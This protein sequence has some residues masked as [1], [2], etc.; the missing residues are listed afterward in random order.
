MLRAFWRRTSRKAAAIREF[1]S[2]PSWITTLQR[3]AKAAEKTVSY[4]IRIFDELS[5]R[6]RKFTFD[7]ESWNTS[8]MSSITRKKLCLGDESR[9]YTV[10]GEAFPFPDRNDSPVVNEPKCMSTILWDHNSP[11]EKVLI[12][13]SEYFPPLLWHTLKPT[14]AAVSQVFSEFV[15]VDAQHM[16][17]QLPY[18]ESVQN[19][20]E[21][22]LGDRL[23]ESLNP[24]HIKN[25]FI[26]DMRKRNPLSISLDYPCE[27]NVFMGTSPHFRVVEDRFMKSNPF[28][29]GWPLLLSEGNDFLEDTPLR[30]AAFRSIFSKSLLLVHSRLDLQVDHRHTHLQADDGIEDIIL[31]TPI[32]CS[33]N[34]PVNQ[35]LCGGRPLVRRF[36]S[37]MGTSF[38]LDTPVDVLAA[39]VVEGTAIKGP[40]ELLC[41]LAF[42]DNAAKK[43]P[44]VE[45]VFRISDS[46]LSANRIVGQ[47]AYT[48]IY[49]A[50]LSHDLFS[51]KVFDSFW[52]HPSDV[53]RVACAKGAHIIGRPDLVQKIIDN[54]GEG[55]TKLMLEST[56]SMVQHNCLQ[57]TAETNSA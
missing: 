48:I 2:T 16:K 27:F 23:T 6:Q 26:E 51:E 24:M 30:M 19:Q 21:M 11:T 55:R 22:L 5:W 1:S 28:V 13:L 25:K 42:L 9:E 45:R 20:M 34:Y 10:I 18:Y 15:E 43:A 44:D 12:Q 40:D 35:R 41:E 7:N 17:A 38:P 36:N 54:E 52:N 3:D 29:F 37:V 39:L 32:F 50:L 31:E 57:S 53:V 46:E 49:L 8:Q 4:D 47:L 14:Y 33:I 56:L